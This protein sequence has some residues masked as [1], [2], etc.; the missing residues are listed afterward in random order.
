MNLVQINERLKDLPMQVLQ[1]YANGMNPEVPP[2][3]ALGEL[4]RRET[5][6][7]QMATAQG[8]QQGPQPSIKEQVEQKAGLMALQQMQQQQAAQQ[9]QQPQGPMP[10]PAGAPQPEMQPQAMMARGGLTSIPVRRDMFEYA[11][12]GIIAFSGENGSEV[13]SKYETAYDRMNRLNREKAAE[14]KA[15]RLEAIRAAGNETMPYGEQMRNVGRA[16]DRAVPDPIELLKTLIS[17]PGYGLSKDD[18]KT[19]RAPKVIQTGSP[20]IPSS[21]AVQ[22]VAPAADRPAPPRAAP[23]SIPSAP[24]PTQAA[25]AAPTPAVQAGLPAALPAALAGAPE[26]VSIPVSPDR[27]KLEALMEEQKRPAPTAEGVISGVS[28][29]MPEGMRDEAMKKRFAEQRARA[30]ARE[31]GYKESQPSGL[32]N[33][34]R[35]LGQAGQYKGFSGIGPAYTALQQQRRAE[36]L[37][38]QKQQ[39]EL[40]TAIEGR[41]SGA[42]KDVFTA[43]TGAMDRAQQMYGQSQKSIIDAASSMLGVD[44]GRIDKQSQLNMQRDLEMFKAQQDKE[45]TMA[46]I[47]QRD[48]A[49]AQRDSESRRTDARSPAAQ[50]AKFVALRQRARELR[51][52]GEVAAANELEA[53]ASDMSAYGGSGGGGGA[54]AGPKPMTRDQATDNVNKILENPMMSRNFIADAKA[55]LSARGVA[56]PNMIQIQEYLIQEQM[57]GAD[58]AAPAQTGKV[59]PP[60][61]GFKVN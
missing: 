49:L 17:A 15:E 1:Q 28:A 43:R 53:Q 14:E 18:A 31:R 29:L 47:G 42:D 33:L 56:N 32:D 40:M 20:D 30:D 5:S 27:A 19:D 61:P 45:R 8:G 24:R 39:D 51:A 58:L 59:P 37:A 36:D 35:V 34:I 50:A 23:A 16:I 38:F 55:G 4:Q 13:K 12:G 10:V 21:P 6:Q 60:P 41:E 22:K 3:L 7:K 57:K 54:G 44:Q 46:D 11:G 26:A 25:A 2:Y 9:M 48:R 52:R